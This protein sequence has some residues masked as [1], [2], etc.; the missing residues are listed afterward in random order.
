MTKARDEIRIKARNE[1]SK[2]K[3]GDDLNRI[4][5]KHIDI[6]DKPGA[7]I[8]DRLL[9]ETISRLIGRQ[10]AVENVKISYER[11]AMANGKK[12]NFVS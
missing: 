12:Y 11:L 9:A 8:Q 10:I 3:T 1:V 4:I 2:A 6:M 7:T 5:A